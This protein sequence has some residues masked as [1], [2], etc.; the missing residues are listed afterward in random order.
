MRRVVFVILAL[1]L[2][3]CHKEVVENPDCENLKQGILN[4]DLQAVK[5]EVEKLT[6]DLHP[7]KN[8]EDEI[9]HSQNIISLINRLN[10]SCETIVV[11]FDCYA[12]LESFPAQSRILIEFNDGS[13]QVTRYIQLFTP[14]NDI[15]RF[16]DLSIE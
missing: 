11:S 10:T 16:S 14:E 6:V 15:L 13:R 5:T 8:A 3:A 9:G 1:T 12:C 7:I 2:A 4:D